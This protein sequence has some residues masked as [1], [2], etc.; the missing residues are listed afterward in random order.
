MARVTSPGGRVAILE[1]AE[2]HEGVLAPLAR[3]FV[4]HVVPRIGALL[5]GGAREE[6]V[7]LQNSIADFPMPKDF[8]EEMEQSGLSVLSYTQI[9]PG[10][11]YLYVAEV[12]VDLLLHEVRED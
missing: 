8:A 12:P 2:P 10:G 3:I 9:H 5:S 6:Y 7:H 11:V 1:F 4:N